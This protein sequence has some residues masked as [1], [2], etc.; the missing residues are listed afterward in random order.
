MLSPV[1]I[2]P[3][4][5]CKKKSP[6]DAGS[7]RKVSVTKGDYKVASVAGRSL[8]EEEARG[9]EGR[10]RPWDPAPA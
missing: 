2:C 1:H 7:D 6:T 3:G 10:A 8:D 5:E 4:T 9:D